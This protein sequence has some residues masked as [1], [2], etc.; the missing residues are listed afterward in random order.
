MALWGCHLLVSLSVQGDLAFLLEVPA[1]WGTPETAAVGRGEHP[2]PFETCTRVRQQF[3]S[4]GHRN[5]LA[6]RDCGA[7]LSGLAGPRQPGSR[8]QHRHKARE[9]S[10][11]PQQC[12]VIQ[13]SLE[14]VHGLR[15]SNLENSRPGLCF[16]ASLEIILMN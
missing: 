10:G 4:G 13:S 6:C 15:H 16:I 5:P 12:A 3:S 7:A 8:P 11:A 9:G 14:H 2:F 1:S